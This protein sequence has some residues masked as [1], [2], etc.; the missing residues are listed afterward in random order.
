MTRYDL[1]VVSLCL[2]WL[3]YLVL[4]GDSVRRKQKMEAGSS[5]Y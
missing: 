3:C 2:S 4:H 1:A 5:E